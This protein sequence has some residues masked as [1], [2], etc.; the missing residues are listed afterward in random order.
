[1]WDIVTAQL[2]LDAFNEVF[3]VFGIFFCFSYNWGDYYSFTQ[4][5][6][7]LFPY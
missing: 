4:V 3:Y 5:Y 2:S 6:V 1:M 7:T